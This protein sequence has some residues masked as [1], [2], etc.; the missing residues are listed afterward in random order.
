LDLLS[1]PKFSLDR[2]ADGFLDKLLSRLRDVCQITVQEF[3]TSK[4]S[5]TLRAHTINWDETSEKEGFTCL[6]A[7]LRDNE[8][9]QF[10]LTANV[11]GRVHGFLIDSIFFVVWIDPDHQ[12]YP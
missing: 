9:W 12:L 2:C 10:A 11:H 1:N 5:K 7:Q 8:P 4:N 3:R 6:N